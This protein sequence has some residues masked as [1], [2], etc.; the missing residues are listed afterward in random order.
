MSFAVLLRLIV[1]ARIALLA[2]R[3]FKIEWNLCDE[4]RRVVEISTELR[5]NRVH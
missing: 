5:D 2:F 1:A 3:E 4:A